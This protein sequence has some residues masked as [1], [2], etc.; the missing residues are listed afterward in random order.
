ML[1]PTFFSQNYN[2]AAF[3]VQKLLSGSADCLSG[4]GSAPLS[5]PLAVGWVRSWSPVTK[6]EGW[7]SHSSGTGPHF[8]SASNLVPGFFQP[9]SSSFKQGK[10]DFYLNA[11]QSFLVPFVFL[12]PQELFSQRWDTA[13]L[14]QGHTV[15]AQFGPCPILG[16]GGLSNSSKLFLQG[17]N[18]ITW[19]VSGV[20]LC[21]K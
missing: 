19:L 17:L 7:W 21:V 20:L 11:K 6:T 16:L 13:A 1:T 10:L 4:S 18:T 15:S 12:A 9:G 5:R 3:G 2:T 8:F 14:L